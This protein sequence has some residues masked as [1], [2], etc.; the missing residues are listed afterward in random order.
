MNLFVI[1]AIEANGRVCWSVDEAIEAL[2]ELA[3]DS[4][5]LDEPLALGH[6]VAD[7]AAER[8]AGVEALRARRLAAS[9]ARG[10]LAHSV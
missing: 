6:E 7:A 4:A 10:P 1:G 8:R 5:A 9:V 2:H 3:A